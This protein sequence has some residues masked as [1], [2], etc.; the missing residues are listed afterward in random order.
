MPIE[1]RGIIKITKG[2]KMRWFIRRIIPMLLSVLV[3]ALLI[4]SVVGVALDRQKNEAEI[5]NLKTQLAERNTIDWPAG[6]MYASDFDVSAD[7]D[8]CYKLKPVNVG[9][10]VCFR[11]CMLY[12]YDPEKH[13]W[14]RYSHRG[15]DYETE[16]TELGAK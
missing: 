6:Y 14:N 7:C 8:E 13:V 3:S 15:T 1:R 2:N 16:A 10:P 12:E 11:G 9:C 5:A 4:T